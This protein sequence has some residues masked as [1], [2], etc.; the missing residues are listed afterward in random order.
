MPSEEDLLTTFNGFREALFESD[1]EALQELIAEDYHGF[2]PQG[3]PQDKAMTLDAY[4]PGGVKLEKYE[5]EELE[6][7][8]I[9][10]V[11]IISGRGRIQGAFGE[12]TFGHDLRFL[13][14][15]VHKDGRWRLFL[16]QS[17]PL[18]AE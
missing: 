11:G 6:T 14:L 8:V 2:D 7:R 10:D 17:T 1:V 13:D 5:V 3:R 9:G 16:S 18:E 15:F 4:R 12:F